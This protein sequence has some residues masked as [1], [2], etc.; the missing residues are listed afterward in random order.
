MTL[1]LV[2]SL[3]FAV[4]FTLA[5]VLTLLLFLKAWKSGREQEARDHDAEAR[6][7]LPRKE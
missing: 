2:L 4:V 5:V 6:W 3:F 7:S 1:F